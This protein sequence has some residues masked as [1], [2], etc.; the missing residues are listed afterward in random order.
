MRKT[1]MSVVALA[2]L[3][4]WQPA[5]AGQQAGGT[6]AKAKAKAGKVAKTAKSGAEPDQSFV[7]EAAR[8]VMLA[9]V[10]GRLAASQASNDDVKKF[11]QRMVD[12]H[13]KANNELSA[14]AQKKNIT[15]PKDL[16]SAEKATRDRLAKLNGAAFDKAYMRDMV[17]DH[18]ND[19]AAFSRESKSGK[20][21]DVK[22][23]AGQTLPTLEDHLKQAR[24]TASAVGGEKGT[25]GKSGKK[26]EKPD[27]GAG[28]R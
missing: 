10:L 16:T 4:A 19:V 28:G 22:A 9:V 3:L 18:S 8:G 21:A 26:R 15:L 1:L 14:L 17:R 13:S 6:Q 5:F 27:K 11:G 12:D 23:W 24:Q 20:D 2:A 7:M 25:S